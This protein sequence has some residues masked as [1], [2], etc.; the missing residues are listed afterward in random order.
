MRALWKTALL[1][2][3]LLPHSVISKSQSEQYVEITIVEAFLKVL[4]IFTRI[5]IRIGKRAI[6]TTNE[7]RWNSSLIYR[8]VVTRQK[9]KTT[10]ASAKVYCLHPHRL[11]VGSRFLPLNILLEKSAKRGGR[12]CGGVTRS[13][14]CRPAVLDPY[15]TTVASPHPAPAS[16]PQ[17]EGFHNSRWYVKVQPDSLIAPGTRNQRFFTRVLQLNWSPNRG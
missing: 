12:G 6:A 8:S 16:L 5:S 3:Q 11:G 15:A 10:Y 14:K 7:R 2:L 4:H 13:G 9:A 1:L 17:T